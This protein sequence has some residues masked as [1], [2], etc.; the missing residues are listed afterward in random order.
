MLADRADARAAGRAPIGLAGLDGP[1]RERLEDLLV[2]DRVGT[3]FAA[4]GQGGEPERRRL[5]ALAGAWLDRAA[6]EPAAELEAREPDPEPRLAEEPDPAVRR[7]LYGMRVDALARL[8]SLDGEWVATRTE[9]AEQAGAGSVTEL[10]S[11][12]QPVPPAET[13]AAFARG[14]I[15]PLDD[16][17]AAATRERRRCWPIPLT[18]PPDPA[19]AAVLRALTGYVPR[20]DATAV[21]QALVRTARGLGR[22]VRLA[23]DP[24]VVPRMTIDGDETA[25]T[26]TTSASSSRS[27]R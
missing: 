27:R 25:T 3:A 10:L 13:A 5:R 19:D 8:A 7:R 15:E 14:A 1:L 16:I 18:E 23:P 24:A 11:A 26:P 20:F 9:A 21:R 12:G 22:D 6:A 2:A 4:A 17:V